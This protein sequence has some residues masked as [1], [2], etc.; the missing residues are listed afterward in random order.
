VVDRG[1]E[2]AALEDAEDMAAF[3]EAM[4]EGGDSIPGST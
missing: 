2:G 3:G 1:L 4:E